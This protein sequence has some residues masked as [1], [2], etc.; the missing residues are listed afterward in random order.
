MTPLLHT[1]SPQPQH[2]ELDLYD[3]DRLVRTFVDDQDTALAAVRAAAPALTQAVE[4]ALPRIAA[5][6]RLLYAGAGTSGRLCMLDSVEL[7]P[8]FSWPRERAVALLAGG[9][10]AMFE[11]VEGAEDDQAQ[12]RRDLQALEPTQHDVLLGVAASG[13]TPYVLGALAAARAT[14]TLT[15]G[16]ANNPATP[17]LSAADIPVLLDTGPEIIAGSTRLKA[18]TA[19]KIALNTFSSALMVRLN[20]VYGQLMVDMKAT[21]AKLIRRAIQLTMRAAEVDEATARAT[22]ERCG[23]SVKLSIVMLRR[24]L[25][26]VPAA[27]LLDRHLGSVRRALAEAQPGQEPKPASD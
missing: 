12:G 8:T 26:P 4:A 15:I 6:G 13:H 20:K 27:A 23:Y 18:G 3:T 2:A 11:A 1:E 7:T 22:L 14:G 19:Q 17:V 21:N 24:R 5:G 25:D 16:I 9:L 10:P